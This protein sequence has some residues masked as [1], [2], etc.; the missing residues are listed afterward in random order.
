MSQPFHGAEVSA[1]DAV[2]FSTLPSNVL[3]SGLVAPNTPPV[4]SALVA[5]LVSLSSLSHVTRPDSVEFHGN[6]RTEP[7][8]AMRW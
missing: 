1:I 5:R 6:C 7:L 4:L 8:N 2:V 3:S